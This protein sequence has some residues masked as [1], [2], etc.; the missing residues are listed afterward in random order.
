[1]LLHFLTYHR[2]KG[3][4]LLSSID[5]E[6]TSKNSAALSPLLP[7]LQW[8]DPNWL[9]NPAGQMPYSELDRIPMQLM[10]HPLEEKMVV[11]TYY[12]R[13]NHVQELS[14]IQKRFPSQDLSLAILLASFFRY[15]A[16]EFDYKR[17]VLSLHFTKKR[18][19]VER[20]L[21]D[22]INGWK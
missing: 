22:E 14:E 9:K 16:F 13:I 4:G 7:N 21:K 12:H 5:N 11:N 15:Y 17:H 20:E 10:Q 1:M 6:P 18:G 3:N 19:L 8:M 2:R